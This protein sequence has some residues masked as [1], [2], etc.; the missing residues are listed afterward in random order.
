MV[1]LRKYQENI[2][3]HSRRIKKASIFGD[4]GEVSLTVAFIAL[5]SPFSNSAAG[6]TNPAAT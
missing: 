6:H 1:A 5:A 3:K 4:F 2:N